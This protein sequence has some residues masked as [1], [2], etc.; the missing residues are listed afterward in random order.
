MAK[1]QFDRIS[2]YV[3]AAPKRLADA[4]EL[5]AWPTVDA[6]GPDAAHRHLRGAVYLAGY[7]VE[8]ALKAYIISRVPGA[9]R[10]HEAITRRATA[11]ETSLDFRGSQ[12]HNLERLW[13]A[14]DLEAGM[15]TDTVVKTAWGVIRKHWSTDLRYAPT[16]LTG[17]N[18]ARQA[19]EAAGIV[20]CFIEDRRRTGERT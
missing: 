7:A 17:R 12:A 3:E 1:K 18:V 15:D 4:R 2:D 19:V 20:H 9:Q 16:H 13:R 10:F 8:C 14:T 6:D 5:L 11:G